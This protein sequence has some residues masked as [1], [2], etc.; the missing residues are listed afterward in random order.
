MPKWRELN[1]RHFLFYRISPKKSI[2]AAPQNAR[3]HVL[4]FILV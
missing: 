2:Q 3:L 4:Q 1:S